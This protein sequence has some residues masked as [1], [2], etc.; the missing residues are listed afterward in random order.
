[1]QC[2]WLAMCCIRKW[3]PFVTIKLVERAHCVL[4]LCSQE[5]EE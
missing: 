5:L 4:V 1:M 3:Y 2:M